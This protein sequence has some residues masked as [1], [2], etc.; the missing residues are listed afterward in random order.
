MRSLADTQA[1]FQSLTGHAPAGDDAC[2][3]KG[4]ETGIAGDVI[5]AA[6][7][8]A[9]GPS[10]QQA[11]G[12]HETDYTKLAYQQGHVLEVVAPDCAAHGVGVAVHLFKLGT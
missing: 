8:A 9:A 1:L 5:A 12:T 10:C 6:A 4:S 7:T 11:P 3:S 2:N